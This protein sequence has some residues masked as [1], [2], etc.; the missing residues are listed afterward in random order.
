M[1]EQPAFK[2]WAQ[3]AKKY[4]V[5]PETEASAHQ[6]YQLGLKPFWEFGLEE[7]RS[8]F[9]ASA[10]KPR[11]HCLEVTG[12]K[13]EVKDIVIP[14]PHLADGIPTTVYT[15]EGVP[16]VPVIIVYFHG[17]G[18]VMADKK[19]YEMCAMTLSKY[20]KAIVVLPE[21]RW[22]PCAQD[23]LAPFTD[24]EAVTRWVLANKTTLGGVAS[25]LVGVAGDSAGGQLACSITYSIPETLAFQVLIYP[26]A[27]IILEGIESM[28]DFWETPGFCGKDMEAMFEWCQL[29]EEPS[30]ASNPRVNPSAP[31]RK[32]EP[33]LS[34]SPPTLV[35]LAQLDPLRDWGISYAGK[36]R[37][38]R[39]PVELRIVDGCPHVFFSDVEGFPSCSAEGHQ[40]VADFIRG[41]IQKKQ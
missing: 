18:L 3:T 16:D 26:V 24:C 4:F 7:S 2:H 11:G 27:D 38:A 9:A 41:L 39:V 15:P 12:F 20:N 33:A 14:V 22:L 6:S 37:D 13:G 35:L 21:Y 17:G 1:S 25:S 34:T 10:H 29:F 8:K 28:K 19:C 32:G 30:H 36:L 23:R 31:R 5:H 40:I